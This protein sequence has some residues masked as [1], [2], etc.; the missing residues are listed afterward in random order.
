MEYWKDVNGFEGFYRVST[1]GRVTSLDRV[2]ADGRKRKGRVLRQ[3]CGKSGQPVVDLM[4]DGARYRFLVARLVASAFIREPDEGDHVMHLDLNKKNNSVENLALMTH[5]EVMELTN[6]TLCE[7]EYIDRANLT[8]EKTREYFSYKD[9]ELI[10]RR[11]PA[12]N[13]SVGENAGFIEGGHVRIHFCGNTYMKGQL[14]YMW[15]FG[16][17]PDY[18]LPKNGDYTDCRIENLYACT[19]SQ[20]ATISNR[21]QNFGSEP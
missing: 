10:W 19:A 17:M 13:V 6:K 14:V 15:H 7:F 9:G 12:L 2:C 5:K 16:E 3:W 20:W 4:V 8:R 11:R 18:V 1:T 21:V